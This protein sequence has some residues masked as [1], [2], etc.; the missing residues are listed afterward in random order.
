MNVRPDSIVDFAGA[1]IVRPDSI[2]DFA[3]AMNVRPH[4]IV[5]IAFAMNVRPD[6]IV[7]IAI[8]NSHKTCTVPVPLSIKGVGTA[9]NVLSD[10]TVE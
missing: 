2:V 4:S 5:E 8:A 1:T 6:S 3:F 7:E 10:K 9:V